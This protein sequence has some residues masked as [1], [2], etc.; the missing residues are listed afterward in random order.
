MGM[1]T[2]V[3]GFKPADE[4]WKKMKAVYDTCIAADL[5]VPEAVN[6]FFGWKKPDENG[7][8]VDQKALWECGAITEYNTLAAQG[9]ELHVDKLPADVTIV[10]FYNAW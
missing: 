9:Y 10:R 7:V 6:E 3:K 4:K 2:H 5:E 8:E 1:S